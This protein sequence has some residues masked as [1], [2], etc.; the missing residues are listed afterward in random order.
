MLRVATLA[1][2]A[3]LASPSIARASCDLGMIRMYT[4]TSG[5]LAG[6]KWSLRAIDSGDGR[7]A[8][9][10]MIGGS[11]RAHHSGRF[12][13]KGANGM[14]VE[15]GFAASTPGTRP[16]FVAGA[17]AQAARDVSIRLSNGSLR[18]VRT[19]PPRCGLSPEIAFFFAPIPASTHP[20]SIS[21][22]DLRGR[23]IVSWTR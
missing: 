10:I 18:T 23:I 22:R 11:R 12:Y 7:Y 9:E 21:G 17:V 8:F 1:V 19:I 13:V 2:L 14:P 16:T 6:T 15:L 5:H 20:V 4:L 3:A